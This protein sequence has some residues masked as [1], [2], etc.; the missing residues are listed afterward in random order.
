MRMRILHVKFLVF[1][2]HFAVE[3]SDEVVEHFA[4]DVAQGV[5]VLGVLPDECDP[6]AAGSDIVL[7][8]AFHGFIGQFVNAVVVQD[9]AVTPRPAQFIIVGIDLLESGVDS[10]DGIQIPV[11]DVLD[12]L[13]LGILGHEQTH[14]VDPIAFTFGR[15]GRHGFVSLEH[16]THVD[17]Q[18]HIIVPD[19]LVEQW[20]LDDILV[21]VIGA[22]IVTACGTQVLQNLFPSQHLADGERAE[23]VEVD[24]AAVL[25]TI[26]LVAFGPL[27]D[28][29]VQTHGGEVAS[30]FE[31]H[32]VA[33]GDEVGERQVTRI[34]VIHQLAEQHT[35]RTNVGGQ[36]QIGT[37]RGF[38][39]ALQGTLVHGTHLVGMVAEVGRRSRI[40]EREHCTD[41]QRTLVVAHREGAAECSTGFT[42]G[43]VAVG[44][45]DAAGSR[46]SILKMAGLAYKTVGQL[47]AAVQV[48]SAT[49][50]GILADDARADDDGVLEGAANGAVG[51]TRHAADLAAFVDDGVDDDTRVD[52]AHMVADGAALGP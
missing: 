47:D 17:A 14:Q 7:M 43:H 31:V 42:I 15:Y 6:L 29:T 32:R 52:Y 20:G 36:Q 45:E 50:D 33:I 30:R 34:G 11:H 19:A 23:P 26:A 37:A 13:F 24:H 27:A 12:D 51:Q 48:G 3:Q 21:V 49:D 1:E 2:V 18:C 35:E 8:D 4:V 40:V 44:K 10:L 25:A 22:H 5:F 16:G 41:E 46:E 9:D 39:T 28:V 38:A